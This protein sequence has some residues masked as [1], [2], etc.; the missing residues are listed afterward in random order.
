MAKC[1]GFGFFGA[2][3][4]WRCQTYDY[5]RKRVWRRSEPEDLKIWP[6]DPVIGAVGLTFIALKGDLVPHGRARVPAHLMPPFF[7]GMWGLEQTLRGRILSSNLMWYSHPDGLSVSGQA[8]WSSEY[9]ILTLSWYHQV[10]VV[11]FLSWFYHQCHWEHGGE[12]LV[13][14]KLVLVS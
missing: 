6:Y 4:C 14:C 1:S 8:R 10:W 5:E 12:I 13:R 7:M 2:I 3:K 9:F 11:A